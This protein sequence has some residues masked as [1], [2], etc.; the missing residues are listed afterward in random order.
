MN[1]YRTLISSLV[2]ATFIGAP[3][4]SSAATSGTLDTINNPQNVVC[5]ALAQIGMPCVGNRNQDSNDNQNQPTGNIVGDGTTSRPYV[6]SAVTLVQVPNETEIYQ[7]INGQKHLI[8]TLDIFYDYG[9]TNGMV[10]VISAAQLNRYPRVRLVQAKGD[11]KHTYYITEGGLIRL[12]PNKKVFEAYGNRSDEIIIISKRELNYY[13]VNQ[14][15]FQEDPLN[16]DVFQ[17]IGGG[18]SYLTPTAVRRMGIRDI[19]VAPVSKA[20]LDAYKML[21]PVLK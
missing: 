18:K 12:I 8:P 9:Y 14:F 17:L 1:K 4:V 11:S 15:V 2:L 3:L 13:P 20:E 19:D 6:K 5:E 7:I 16:K 10:Q 21:A